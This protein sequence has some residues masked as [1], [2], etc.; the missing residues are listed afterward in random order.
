[1]FRLTETEKEQALSKIL[2]K[3]RR[4]GRCIVWTGRRTTHGYGS[5]R[6]R[7]RENVRVTRLVW[8][9]KKGPIPQGRF[10][11][12]RC[13]NPPC[14]RIGHLFLGTN[15]DNQ[16]DAR[17][18]GRTWRAIGEKARHA[19]LTADAVRDIRV[20]LANGEQ[21][22]KIAASLGRGRQTIYDI[23]RGDS[24]KYVAES[25]F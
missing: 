1:L 15:R 6:F 19:K 3:L 24:W 17:V 12:H 22:P 2:P 23:R 21:A 7:G 10:V 9:S 16:L 20:R 25:Y 4:K 5:I 18:K 14:T 11:C 13:D 8:A